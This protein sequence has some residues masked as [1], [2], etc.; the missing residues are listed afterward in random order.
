M[1]RHPRPLLAGVMGWPV[2]HSRSPLMHKHWMT[3]MGLKGA[4]VPLA[5]PPDGLETA[6][7]ALPALGFAGCNLTIPHKQA[8]LAFVDEI[9]ATAHRIGAISCVAVRPDGSLFGTNNDWIGFLENLRQAR[10]GWTAAAG[11]AVVVGAGGGARAI[12][13]AL[14][15]DGVPELRLVNRNRSRAEALADAFG[16]P[17]RVHDWADRAS[18]LDGAALLVNC[19]SLG[20]VGNPPLDLPLAALSRAALVADIVYTPLATPLIE[21]ARARGNDT[22]NGLGMLLH[23]GVPAWQLWFGLTPVVSEDLR[24]R[25]EG[26]IRN[27]LAG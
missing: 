17:I 24:R 12:C 16:G 23:Q 27:A 1:T 10:R 20:M 19:T 18:L 9:D 6:L 13:H 22:V 21:A 25:L 3:E 5:I 8:A 7:R 26:D 11:P 15:Q 2:L 4:Y 14:L